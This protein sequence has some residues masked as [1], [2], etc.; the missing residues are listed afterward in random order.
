LITWEYFHVLINPMPIYGLSMGTLAMLIA[1]PM[2]NRKAQLLALCLIFVGAA[3]A[4]PAY[5][6][7]QKAYH[8]VYVLADSDG[9][10][11]LD[12]HLHRSEKLIYVFY[13]VAL[14]AVAAAL[15]PVKAPKTALPLALFTLIAAVGA[16]GV[17]GWIA[18]AGGEVRHPEFRSEQGE[19]SQF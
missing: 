8:K 3:S 10:A 15:V 17:G 11:S 2:R 7:G 1:L 6:S 13:G 12:A 16:L 4:F 14:L 18:K 19:S 5:L 9:Q